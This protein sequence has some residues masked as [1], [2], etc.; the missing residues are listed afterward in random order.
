M[1]TTTHQPATLNITELKQRL[2][3]V[4]REVETGSA[5]RRFCPTCNTSIT[6]TDVEAGR[7]T[8][9]GVELR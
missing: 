1:T 8:N 3:Q 7:C 4:R 2:R 9:C 6:T 5:D